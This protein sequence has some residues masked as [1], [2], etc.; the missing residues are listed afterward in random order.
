MPPMPHALSTLKGAQNQCQD[1]TFD[2]ARKPYKIN[3]DCYETRARDGG[4]KKRDRKKTMPTSV[5][6]W[7]LKEENGRSQ[8]E[9][10]PWQSWEE[11]RIHPDLRIC[12]PQ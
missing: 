5:T 8:R 12:V 6:E 11:C 4:K 10:K 1:L 9:Q 7:E 3:M 2:V